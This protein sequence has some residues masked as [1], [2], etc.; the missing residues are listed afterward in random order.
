MNMKY[1]WGNL[2]ERAQWGETDIDGRDIKMYLDDIGWEVV[3]CI[4]LDLEGTSGGLL[5]LW[6]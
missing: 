5:W 3:D 4:R 1:I 2:I 6:E